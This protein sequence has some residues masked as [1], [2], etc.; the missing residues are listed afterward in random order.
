MPAGLAPDGIEF[1]HIG[2]AAPGARAEVGGGDA[3]CTRRADRGGL[4]GKAAALL[5]RLRLPRSCLGLAKRFGGVSPLV[6]S[7]WCPRRHCPW[8]QGLPL[9]WSI[10]VA[11]GGKRQD[12]TFAF[13]GGVLTPGPSA[14]HPAAGRQALKPTSSSTSANRPQWP[15]A[16]A[17]VPAVPP[18]CQPCRRDAR[19]PRSRSGTR[20]AR[21]RQNRHR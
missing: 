2:M 1:Q 10:G 19:P 5:R 12:L 21:Q 14:P 16:R 17:T 7:P 9:V 8:G 18:P 15:G 20:S 11:S 6:G 3:H 13:A 4:P